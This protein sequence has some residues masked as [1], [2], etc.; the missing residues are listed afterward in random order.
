MG[1]VMGYEVTPHENSGSGLMDEKTSSFFSVFFLPCSQV[2]PKTWYVLPIHNIFCDMLVVLYP[3]S[4]GPSPPV[5]T[6]PI[7]IAWVG[8][9]CHNP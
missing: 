9:F 5:P 3:S 2:F 6:K 4:P 8:I 1:I 7:G